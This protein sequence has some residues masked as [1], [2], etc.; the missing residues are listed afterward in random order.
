MPG[1]SMTGSDVPREVVEVAGAAVLDPFPLGV[2]EHLAPALREHA[3]GA[4]V[5]TTSRVRPKSRQKLQRAPAISRT[6]VRANSRTSAP[7]SPSAS[8]TA[9]KIGSS[10]SADG[11]RLPRCW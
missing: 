11:E 7:Q 1:A 10:N 2:G 6:A 5:D 4:R 9:Q 8:C 3:A